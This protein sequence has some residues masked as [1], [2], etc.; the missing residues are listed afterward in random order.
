MNN[1]LTI[2]LI[3]IFLSNCSYNENSSFWTS[4]KIKKIELNSKEQVVE[5]VKEKEKLN[6]EFNAIKKIKLKSKV[7]N[8]SFINNLNNNNGRINFNGN[9]KKIS[10]Y[11]FSKIKNFHNYDPKMIS[12]KQDIIF[13]DNTG[14]I[15]R[16]NNDSKLVWKTNNYKKSEKK[17][18]PI[19]FFAINNK[20]LIVADNIAKYYALNI[21]TGKV[22]WSK[23][24]S[25]PFNSELKTYKSKFFIID[26]ENILRAY[27]I[28][29][30]KEVWNV[31][32]ENSLV[33]T[34]KKLSMVIVDNIIYF[35]N[36][37]GDISAVDI[38]SGELLWQNP[39]QSNLVNNDESFFLKTSDLITDNQA[40]YFSNDKNQFYSLDIKTGIINWKQKVNS[41]LLPTIIDNYIFTISRDGF[42]Y[43]INKKSGDIVRTTNLLKNFKKKNPEYLN[44]CNPALFIPLV[45]DVIKSSLLFCPPNAQLVMF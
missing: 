36:S 9:L 10:K 18:N 16:F 17:K 29:N 37:L 19:L 41:I 38:N 32:T 13:F 23:S 11:K 6:L 28:N 20:T 42:L 1:I 40:L 3:F 24:N 27:S 31:K 14:S 26:F 22:L 33:R 45:A 2:L 7:T 12:Y 5:K 8:N 43:I 35:N 21:D 15:M 4:K 25:S 39:T 34:Q 44:F 30:A